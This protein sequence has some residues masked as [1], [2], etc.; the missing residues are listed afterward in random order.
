M[1]EHQSTLS[2]FVFER[3]SLQESSRNF[4]LIDIV[5]DFIQKKS[6]PNKTIVC[7]H[8]KNASLQC[9]ISSSK[10]IYPFWGYGGP[11]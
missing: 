6:L 1:A 4:V 2:L 10:L 3:K 9:L 7:R 5:D 11:L 8:L